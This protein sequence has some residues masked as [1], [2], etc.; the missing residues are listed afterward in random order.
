MT[1]PQS[2]DLC[3][4][5]IRWYAADMLRQCISYELVNVVVWS[6]WFWLGARTHLPE[7]WVGL[8]S[9]LDAADRHCVGD[10]RSGSRV[11]RCSVDARLDWTCRPQD[12]VCHKSYQP[13]RR[14][15]RSLFFLACGRLGVDVERLGHVIKV[16]QRIS[17]G[18]C[19]LLN[20]VHFCFW[21]PRSNLANGR[22]TP[23]QTL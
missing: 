21:H 19:F 14:I 7:W 6:R 12:T 1:S 15:G 17:A 16:A 20:S 2:A 5:T 23:R 3:T 22:E 8:R 18:L 4:R 11:L 13:L 9:T 10:C